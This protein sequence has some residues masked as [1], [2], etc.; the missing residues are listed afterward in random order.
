MEFQ[1]QKAKP[2]LPILESTSV[3]TLQMKFLT[4]SARERQ[5]AS[6]I[7]CLIRQAEFVNEKAPR[8]NQ[9]LK[10]RQIK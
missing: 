3:I 7:T 9:S 1:G 5:F 6:G 2:V 4:V 8:D 10:L